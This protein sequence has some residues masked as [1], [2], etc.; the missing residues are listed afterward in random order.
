MENALALLP[1]LA[2]LVA[3][4]DFSTAIFIRN[5]VQYAVRQGVRYAITSQTMAGMGQDASIKAVVR[6]NSMGFL[7]FLSPDRDG[8]SLVSITY[9]DSQTMAPL[10]G[11]GSNAGGNI[12][13]VA[14]NNLS[15]SWMV[16]LLRNAAPLRFSV[17]SSDVM[18]ASPGGIP[19][20]R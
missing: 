10:T 15:W 7:D 18:E 5:T 1:V 4:V 6:Q 3:I 20:T 9:Y 19:P 11:L 13:V 8:A 16:P 12:V 14:A 17:A 2:L